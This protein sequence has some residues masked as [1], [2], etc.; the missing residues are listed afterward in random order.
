MII[1]I[2]RNSYFMLPEGI[3]KRLSKNLTF[4]I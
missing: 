3:S 2:D 4:I 1:L